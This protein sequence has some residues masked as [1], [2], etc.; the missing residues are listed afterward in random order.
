MVIDKKG[1]DFLYSV[2]T[3]FDFVPV[4]HS[5]EDETRDLPPPCIGQ[6]RNERVGFMRDTEVFNPQLCAVVVSNPPLYPI[7]LVFVIHTPRK[8]RS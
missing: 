1:I 2:V 8:T 6:E 3:A 7:A 4:A 5:G